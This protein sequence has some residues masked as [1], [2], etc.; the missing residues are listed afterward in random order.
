MRNQFE[1][2]NSNI[3]MWNGEVVMSRSEAPFLRALFKRVAYLRPESVLEVGFG[4][5]IS[6]R[7][8]QRFLKP[9]THDIVEID[10]TIF[11]DLKSFAASQHGVRGILAD[12]ASLSSEQVLYDFIFYD[13][14]DFAQDYDYTPS[15]ADWARAQKRTAK[16][17][18]KLLREGGVVCVPHFGGED[19]DELPGFDLMFFEKLTVRPYLLDDGRYSRRGGVACW[20]R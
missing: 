14:F 9:R 19:L 12:W 13:P 20:R 16:G 15:K 1:K 18:R 10:E 11:E 2:K 7:L 8:I 4:L 6:A 3:I 17:L 5:G